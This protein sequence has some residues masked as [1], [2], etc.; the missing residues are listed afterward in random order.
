MPPSKENGCPCASQYELLASQ[1]LPVS[2]SVS[3]CLPVP[4]SGLPVPLSGFLCFP[5]PPSGSQCLPVCAVPP[6]RPGSALTLEEGVQGA[7]VVLP[8]VALADVEGDVQALCARADH[9]PCVQKM[10]L[11]QKWPFVQKWPLCKMALVQKKDPR[12]KKAL[13]KKW[14]LCK[15]PTALMQK[16]P[17]HPSEKNP[18]SCKKWPLC[19]TLLKST[20]ANNPSSSPCKTVVQKSSCE[21]GCKTLV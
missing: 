1:C 17:P 12:A 2:P 11:V 7:H 9:H 21:S 6:L 5:V 3:H 13:V 15:N 18:P 8:R 14:P 19:N 20:G 10:A 4:P 16:N